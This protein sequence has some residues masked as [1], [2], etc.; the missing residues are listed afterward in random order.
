MKKFLSLIFLLVFSICLLGCITIEGKT[1]T[2]ALKDGMYQGQDTDGTIVNIMF[3]EISIMEYVKTNQR[4]RMK[5]LYT[6]DEKIYT[7]YY[8]T[9]IISNG[10]Y[11]TSL[12][13]T[14]MKAKDYQTTTTYKVSKIIAVG[15]H[16]VKNFQIELVDD[17]NDKIA[18]KLN[19][20]METTKSNY[21]IELN[22]IP[23]SGDSENFNISKVE[24]N[25]SYNNNL[26]VE[27]HH[28]EEENHCVLVGCMLTFYVSSS[29]TESEVIM[30]VNGIEYEIKDVKVDQGR[31]IFVYEYKI[32]Y[33]SVDI[34]FEAELSNHTHNY[35]DGLCECG[36]FDTVW[37][38]ENFR[39]TDEQILFK[40]SVDDE[41]AC[42]VIL[43]TLKFT[44]TNIELSKKHFGIEE[45]TQVEYLISAPPNHFYEPGNE[46]ML[47][48]F[49]QI[50]FLHVDV[51]SKDEIIELIIE[52][53]KLPFI[54]S[55][56]PNYIGRYI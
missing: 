27:I 31:K 33:N 3:D 1:F 20:N 49:H 52:I 50:V 24:Y 34:R 51:D 42:D 7:P 29:I 38:N 10:I 54:R 25:L 46:D 14:G 15:N 8:V 11:N 32:G 12:E 9:I 28:Y 39:L 53:E 48:N 4:N 6:K 55:A 22:Y 56:E 18:E 40:G 36:Q 16:N 41:F 35:T 13:F 19:V 44:P 21:M 26:N 5:D 47:N 43:L 37:L 30:Y 2:I 17:D 45:V 23:D